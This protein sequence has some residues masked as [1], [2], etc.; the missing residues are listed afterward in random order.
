LAMLRQAQPFPAFPPE[1]T[2]GSMAF[3]VP[4]AFVPR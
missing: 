4:L 1:I 2:Q 3:S